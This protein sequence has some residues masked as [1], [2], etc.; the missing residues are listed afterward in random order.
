MTTYPTD[1]HAAYPLQAALLLTAGLLCLGAWLFL[2]AY[3]LLFSIFCSAV[4]LAALLGGFVLFPL[5]LRSIRYA[6]TSGQ[7]TVRAGILFRREHSVPL[8]SVQFAESIQ[9]PGGGKWGMNFIILHVCGG[10]LT[11][12]FLRRRDW[13]GIV[14][15]LQKKGVY[16]AP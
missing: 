13:E 16:H 6:V 7:I 9:G 11:M 4:L 10:R 12:V 8:Q 15:F 2:R 14:S 5:Y 3:S 1:P